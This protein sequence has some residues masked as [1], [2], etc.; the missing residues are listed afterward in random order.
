MTDELALTARRFAELQERAASRNCYVYTSFLT[1]AEQSLF[2]SLCPNERQGS[3]FGGYAQAER[4][5][6]RFGSLQE[7]GYDEPF[8]IRFLKL[9][10]RNLKYADQLTHRDV[11]GALMSAGIERDTLGDI[12]LQGNAAYLV[13]AERIAPFLCEQITTIRHTSVAVEPVELLP[14]YTAPAAQE[15]TITLPSLRLDALVGEVYRISRSQSAALFDQ[16]D[17]FL[18]TLP[19]SRPDAK[20]GPGDLISV[21]HYGRFTVQKELGTTRK[22]GIKVMI[23]RY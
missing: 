8:P 23:A 18:N 16:G 11:L 9:I 15:Q 4:R 14:T 21:R 17:V 12:L 13:C 6:G 7:L 22:G 5:M 19:V 2:C 10:P 20:A 3:L 1:I